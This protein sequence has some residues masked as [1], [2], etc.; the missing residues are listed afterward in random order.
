[1]KKPG[2]D[3]RIAICI[4]GFILAILLVAAD[5][6]FDIPYHLFSA[7]PTPINWTE[8]GIESIFILIVGSLTISI[9][10]RLNLKRER[11]EGALKESERRLSNILSS[12][13][14]LVFVLDKDSRFTS[15]Y[16]PSNELYVSPREFMGKKYSDIMPPHVN[17]L[18]TEALDKN[19]KGEVAEFEYWLE[20]GD[21][22][23]WYYAKM[24]PMLVDGEFAGCVA[25]ARN[26]TERKQ[27]QE[28]I[29]HLHGTLLT[30]RKVNQLIV[31]V[32]DE[33]ELIQ[34]VCATLVDS[35]N[36]K[37]AWIGFTSDG[38]YDVLPV[39]QAGFEEGYLSSVKITYDDSEYGKGPTGTA[40][41]TRRPSVMRGIV[42][43]ERYQPWREQ[44]L[45]RGYTS[46]AA[47]PLV[48]EDKTI[49]ALSVY[50]AEP[51]A[52]GDD[53]IDML[54]ELA[55]DI[56]LGI[57]KIRQ[58]GE[59]RQSEEE[60]KQFKE[61]LQLQID[62]MPTALIVWDTGFRV[63]SWNPAAE[64]MFGFTAEEALGKHPYDLI[65]P[66]EA[67]PHVDNIWRRLLKGDTTAHSVNENTTKDGQTIICDWTN[68]P[69]KKA[70]GTVIGVLSMVQ[71]ITERE[72]VEAA[73]RESEER[74]R[75]LFDNANDLLHS[76]KPDGHFLYVN[77]KWREVLGYSEEEVTNL[78]LW[79]IIHSDSLPHCREASRRVMSGEAVSKI[80]AVF[81]AKDGRLI[82]V[83]GT[84]SCRFEDGK[85]VATRDIFRDISER[86]QA[87][88]AQRESEERYRE[89]ANLLPQ[90]ICETDVE[91]NITF[92][93]RNAFDIFGY[94]PEDLG[95][96]LTIWQMIIPEDLDRAR[97][98]SQRVLGGE[99]LS[100]IEYTAK[101]KDG[102]TFSVLIYSSSITHEDSPTGLRMIIVDITERKKMEE[103]LMVNDRLASIGE[104]ASGIAHELNNPLTSVIGFSDLLMDKDIP[105]DI[106]EDLKVINREAHRTAGVIRNLLTFARKHPQE[107]QPVDINKAIQT[108]LDLR[109][110]EQ[111]VSNIE[112]NTHLASDLPEITVDG[113]QLQ[114][115]FL[116]II[117][118]AEHFMS[119][120]HGKGTLTITTERVGDTIRASFA[121]DGPG[122]AKENLGHLFEPFFTT[123][124][125]GKGTGLGL[126]ISHGVISAH[127]G[128]INAESELGKGATFVVDLPI[129]SE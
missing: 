30:I 38:S 114:Q 96:G 50:S 98:D 19:K 28:K 66:K 103:Q 11:A 123:K 87:E 58:Q 125:V 54:A 63:Q 121:D 89:L 90:T 5:E 18:M 74:Y 127:G 61:H 77:K 17:K 10:W 84:S 34:R 113:F 46:S 15:F 85:P 117:I 70:D 109:A 41:K 16:V 80:K 53:E 128:R 7:P 78:T 48:V 25:V 75:D 108:V 62:R 37:M 68:T 57:G 112:V 4:A 32:D 51:D 122:I 33:S 71:D 59:L 95:S 107:K 99:D 97:E 14:D 9:L 81:V 91:G 69:L 12:M 31:E 47:L 86:K 60:L 42:N 88:E 64:T 106:K 2:F 49:G 111:R 35:R 21:Q 27:T 116:N 76:V 45:K 44:A 129:G 73:L 52:F 40:I 102:S 118:N 43:D 82:N 3:A 79:D 1:M 67:Q 8:S 55:G 24:S 110:Y 26:I 94:S 23:Q 20:I 13:V 100:G 93:N 72:Q 83:E 56:S 22:T 29:L 36:Y 6:I 105:D 126:S 124:E 39:A 92:V 119:E 65:V 120:A 104:L 115:V 101:R